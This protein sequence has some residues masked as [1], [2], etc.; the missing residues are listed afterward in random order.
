MSED[1]EIQIVLQKITGRIRCREFR[2]WI[3]E[4]MERERW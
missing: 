4:A 3:L 2:R 1:E